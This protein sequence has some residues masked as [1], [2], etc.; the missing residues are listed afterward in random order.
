MDMRVVLS[1]LGNWLQLFGRQWVQWA[2]IT[3][4]H[5]QAL[6]KLVKKYVVPDRFPSTDLRPAWT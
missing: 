6:K 5:Q 3:H 4:F 1:M 2:L